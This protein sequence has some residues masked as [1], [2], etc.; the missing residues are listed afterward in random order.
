MMSFFKRLLIVLW[1]PP[2]L[3]LA[4]WYIPG[5][6]FSRSGP[7]GFEPPSISATLSSLPLIGL[8]GF[9]YC[10]IPSMISWGYWSWLGGLDRSC[11]NADCPANSWVEYWD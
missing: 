8:F 10:L 9:G 3:A 11:F 5:M 2:I 6:F 7:Q 4:L 1:L